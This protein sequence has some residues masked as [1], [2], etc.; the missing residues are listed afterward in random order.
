M[1]DFLF[2]WFPWL[3][4]TPAEPP[5]LARFRRNGGNC[6]DCG[7]ALLMGPEGGCAV[8]VMCEACEHQFNIGF[9]FGEVMSIERIRTTEL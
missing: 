1:F 4:K 8:N 7:S 3:R 6:P 2:R 9:A 5:L